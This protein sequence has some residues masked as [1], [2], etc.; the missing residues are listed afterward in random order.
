MGTGT[1][2]NDDPRD[3]VVVLTK[4]GPSVAPPHSFLDYTIGYENLGPF[5]SEN[6]RVIDTLPAELKFVSAS[7][8]G[9]FDQE[10]RVVRWTLGT[11]PVGEDG[12]LTLRVRIKK[13]V[14]EDT[15]VVNRAE[16]RADLTTATPASAETVVRD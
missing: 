6:A 2:L 5:D 13:W 3:P 15:V 8:G 14:I 11:V 12:E 10:R 7:S 9:V 1:I 16:Y 4:T